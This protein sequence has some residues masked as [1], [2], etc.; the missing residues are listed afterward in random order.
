MDIYK[1]GL[2]GLLF[3]FYSCDVM[4][5]KPFET[6]T[7]DLVWGAKETIDA[8][9]IKTYPGTI[10][11]FAGNS[12][13]WEALT[14]HSAECDQVGN[15]INDIATETGLSAYTDYGFGRFG[16]QRRC[17]LILEK[18]ATSEILSEE[19]KTNLMAEAYFLRGAL[20]FDMTRK[21]GRFVPIDRVLNQDDIEAF[22]TP[23]TESV[24]ESYK[25]IM[26]DLDKA[27]EGLPETSDQGRANKYAALALRSRAALQAY[28]YTKDQH[29]LDVVI[30]SS[31]EVIDSGV[32]SLT[33][34][35]GNMFNEISPN[36]NEI[37]LGQYFLSKDASI[38]SFPE[39]ISALPTLDVS[40]SKL[41]SADGTTVFT[42][43]SPFG[44][45]GIHWP[46]QDLVD[47]Y[48]CVDEKTGEAKK[49]NETSQFIENVEDVT[50]QDLTTGEIESFKRFDGQYRNLPSDM[51]LKTGRSDY[52]LFKCIGKIKEGSSRT[53][54]D[55]MYNNRDKRMDATVIRDG[56]TF[57]GALLE[58]KLGG[59][60][61]QGVRAKED[62]GW[63]TT[64]TG[65][66]WKKNVY[67]STP[68][69]NAF[70]KTD[71][72]Y[73]IFRLGEMYVNMAEAYLLKGNV[74][75]AVEALN[76]TRVKHGGL[77][78]S[79]ATDSKIAWADYLRERRVE[80]AYEG[81]DIYFSYL[82]WG[83]YGGACNYDRIPGETLKDLNAPVYKINITSDR[84]I[85]CIS[86]LTVLN[87]WNRNFTKRRYLFPIPQGA[88]DK[89]SADGIIDKQ[90]EGW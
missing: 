90:N 76:V 37:I 24:A 81:G 9:V 42:E 43:E 85:F 47:Q 46:T 39:M 41:A 38:G 68:K 40:E 60:A 28:A 61:S 64:T 87:S 58:T 62:G 13:G 11:N 51:D 57:A 7:D 36:D 79:T 49:W 18:V 4:D 20:Y 31:K 6:Y 82:R 78:P 59:N 89:R 88:I 34:N 26:A 44:G 71:M 3:F 19:Q 75:K 48:L 77:P 83:K 1:L 69:L 2:I 35:Y 63:Y 65:Y 80:M 8:F 70:Q 14:P 74:V 29:Y 54:S 27:V 50:T 55:I 23:L 33:D 30:S 67:T 17:N 86:Q 16:E 84:K 12:P 72:H 32:Y 53:V 45:W 66:Y 56:S 73:V 52:H 22:R 15:R 5:T 10:T 25:L 21:M